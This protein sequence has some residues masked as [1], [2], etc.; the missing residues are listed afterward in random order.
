MDC[1]LRG[2]E[3]YVIVKKA[4]NIALILCRSAEYQVWQS[5]NAASP[6]AVIIHCSA[7]ATRRQPHKGVFTIFWDD[8]SYAKLAETTQAGHREQAFRT[9]HALKGV[10]ANLRFLQ[11]LTSVSAL[12]G[13]LRP[14]PAPA[15]DADAILVQ[16]SSRIEGLLLFSQPLL[17]GQL[18][19]TVQ[20][21]DV[22]LSPEVFQV[23]LL[24]NESYRT[25]ENGEQ[26]FAGMWY[27]TL[28][29]IPRPE[30][31]PET[32]E[33]IA[34]FTVSQQLV[35]YDYLWVTETEVPY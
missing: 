27:Q 31:L 4:S 22:T 6:W 17:P 26:I 11:L 28:V 14:A 32:G 24:E 19:L 3:L 34:R 23:R 18:R 7:A 10:C 21:D 1:L 5:R 8:G 25:D 2:A 9:A 35:N 20:L 33:H 29:I 15:P 16:F 30:D 13:F 12:T